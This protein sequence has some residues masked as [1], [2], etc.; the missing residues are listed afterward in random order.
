MRGVYKEAENSEDLRKKAKKSLKMIIEI[1]NHLP[2]LEPL[3]ME[4]QNP[5][6]LK[7][8]VARFA[9]ILPNN[10]ELRKNFISTGGFKRIQEIKSSASSESK[11]L[12]Y[13]NEINSQFPTEVINYYSPDFQKSLMKKMNEFKQE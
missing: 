11:L 9:V 3:L 8:V 12:E 5:S 13:I 10:I 6:I 1:C 4:A 2:A 7:Y